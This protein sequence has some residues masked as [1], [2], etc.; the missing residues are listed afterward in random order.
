MM[1][2]KIGIRKGTATVPRRIAMTPTGI[3]IPISLK[4]II[5]T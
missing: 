5:I 4:L 1:A 3:F 2:T